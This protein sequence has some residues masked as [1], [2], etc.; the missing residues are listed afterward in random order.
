VTPDAPEGL[1]V[2]VVLAHRATSDATT[3]VPGRSAPSRAHPL[4]VL[5]AIGAGAVATI[6]L[7]WQ[8]TPTVHGFG[9]WLTNAGRIT[10]LLAGYGVVVLVALMARIPP[11]E[12]GVGA[13]R[14][15]R[16]HSQGGRYIVSLVVAHGL[17]IIWGYAVTAHVGVVSQTRTLL[18]NYPDVMAATVAGC[19]LV[20]VGISSARAARRRL[21][22]ETWYY[23]H[24]Y[25][26]LAVAL[27]FSHQFATGAEFVDDLQ[28]RV[29]WAAMYGVV[30]VAVVWYRFLTPVRQAVRHRMRVLVVYPEGPGVVSA[31]I[32]GRH[33]DELQAESGQF[34]RWRFLCRGLWWVSSP[35]SLS[36][37]PQPGQLRITVKDLGDHSRALAEVPP[38]TKVF[39]EGPYGA[40]TQAVR[41]RHKVLLIG[42]GVGITPLRALFETLPAGPGDLTL[43][44]RAS[45]PEDIVFREE[46]QRLAAQRGASLRFVTGRRADLGFDPLSAPALRANIPDLVDHEVYLCGPAG[47]TDAVTDA[48]RSAGVPRRQIHHEFFEF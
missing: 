24:F 19:L 40:V 37:G 7:W 36:A 22:Y 46:L 31:I 41:R 29:V 23:L 47:M 35:Y 11:L 8:N 28:A 45:R 21:R 32:A 33:L 13:D 18:L 30:G 44:Y 48:L 9:D 15:A 16:W 14:L 3:S 27:A 42:G 5:V 38:G 34:F 26:Y 43:V 12:R 1:D 6:A 17:L 20:G 25:T 10:G 2:T 4:A 39:A